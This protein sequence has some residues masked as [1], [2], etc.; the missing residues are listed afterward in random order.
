MNAVSFSV[1]KQD[2]LWTYLEFWMNFSCQQTV[3]G[4]NLSD[5]EDGVT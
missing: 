2:N 3:L 4:T 5:F 1:S